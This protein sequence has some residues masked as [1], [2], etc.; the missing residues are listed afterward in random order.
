ML[1]ILTWKR[2]VRTIDVVSF[3]QKKLHDMRWRVD[4][5]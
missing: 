5:V 2:E 3:L 1:S 4:A